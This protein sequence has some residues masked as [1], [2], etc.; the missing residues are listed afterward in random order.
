MSLYTKNGSY[1][2]PLPF[3]IRLSNGMTRTEPN[4][5]TAEEIADAGYSVAQD[6]PIPNSVQ[7]VHWDPSNS[8]WYLSDKTL[9]ELQA[10]KNALWSEIRKRRDDMI[11]DVSWRYERLARLDRLGLPQ[12]DDINELD[13]YVQKLAD[14][15]QKQTDPY[16]IVWP[17]YGNI[18]IAN[19]VI[20]NT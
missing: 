3:R 5:F 9:E 16:D 13:K 11:A 2:Q 8:T 20:A 12:I 19:T 15:P 17:I 1:P 10:E 18:Q 14:L 4:T 7:T 6:M